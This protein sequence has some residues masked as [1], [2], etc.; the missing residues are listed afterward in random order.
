MSTILKVIDP[1]WVAV[2]QKI[3]RERAENSRQYSS[4]KYQ[5]HVTKKLPPWPE[6]ARAVPNCF[7]RS[8]LFGVVRKGKGNRRVLNSERINSLDGIEIYYSGERLDQRDLDVWENLLHI[9]RLQEL[10]TQCRV[11]SYALLKS[12][13]KTDSGKNRKDLQTQIERLRAGCLT[14]KHKQYT[15][16]GSLIDEA[17]KDE[18]TKEWVI[19]FNPKMHSLFAYDQFTQLDWN[20]RRALKGKSL[21]QWLDRFYSSHANPFNYKVETLH[22]LCGS[23]INRRDHF[24]T[25]LRKALEEVKKARNQEGQGFNYTIDKND[26]V[27]VN[28]Q[29]SKSQHRHKARKARASRKSK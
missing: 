7:L 4:D 11:K 8:A 18:A 2:R 15:F 22:M 28:K 25:E 6:H 17:F 29:P 20:V 5:T 16:I 23:E 21:A 26:L 9:S 1:E 27:T 10:G 14:I 13:G 24:R 12:L 3:S 19:V